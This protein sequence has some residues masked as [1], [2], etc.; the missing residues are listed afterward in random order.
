MSKKCL[1][2]G[3]DLSNDNILYCPKCCDELYKPKKRVEV[4]EEAIGKV[5]SVLNI[6]AKVTLIL[7]T[8]AAIIL[9]FVGFDKY[10]D[11]GIG[12]ELIIASIVLLISSVITWAALKVFCNISN[13]LQ[14]I[15]KK[16]KG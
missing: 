14:E 2:C 3:C 4:D 10:S 15:N 9:F 13:N 11:Y 16:M 6:I 1:R 5:E 7:G 8:I 12:I